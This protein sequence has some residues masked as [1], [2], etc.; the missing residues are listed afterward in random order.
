MAKK[1]DE[2][3]RDKDGKFTTSEAA[4]NEEVLNTTRSYI[5][6]SEDSRTA[7]DKLSRRNWA[8]YFS[9]Q[10]WT[11]KK[12]GQSKEFSPLTSMGV[13]SVAAFVKRTLTGFGNYF[14]MDIV[15]ES[16]MTSQQARDLLKFHLEDE[17]TD[18]VG[19]AVEPGIKI[20]LLSSVAIFKVRH[21]V[22]DDEFV[23][24]TDVEK[25]ER[26]FPDPTGRGLYEVHETVKDLHEIV[27]LAKQ[28]IYDKDEVAKV[29]TDFV[30]QDK[31]T[32][33]ERQKNHSQPVH[34][35]RKRITLHEVHGTIVNKEGEVIEEGIVATMANKKYLIRKPRKNPRFHKK[36]PFVMAPIIK[37][38]GSVWHKALYDDAVRINLYM[39]ELHNLILDGGLAAAH[40]VKMLRK[41]DLEDPDQASGGVPAGTTLIVKDDAPPNSKV[42]ETVK[43]GEVPADALNVLNLNQ[44]LFDMASMFNDIKAG[45]LPQK[46]V[47]ATEIVEKEQATSQQ[48]DGFA[49]TVE[50]AIDKV[51]RLAWAEIMQFRNNYFD[52]EHIIGGKA[53]L[54]L[55]MMSARERYDMFAKKTEFKVN[56]ISSLITRGKNFQK[57]MVAV[58]AMFKNPILAQA[59]SQRFSAKKIIDK[60]FEG[61]DLDASSIE[62]DK[63]EKGIPPEILQQLFGGQKTGANASAAGGRNPLPAETIPQPATKEGV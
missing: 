45:V 48:L 42:M 50:K 56:G 11:H 4:H 36:S 33:E 14:S 51:L 22:H 29:Q 8:A 47:K 27:K 59:F 2:K 1:K 39:N 44:R 34:N 16:I 15:N 41:G 38:P 19:T 30:E 6:E 28:G 18:F 61:L 54:A 43:T 25:P 60:I 32:E 40:D 23:L 52:V 37:V 63:G 49:R 62:L 10:D 46:Q 24:K 3:L 13:E 58:D 31:L 9:R 17:K 21:E 20:A 7:R 57:L 53:A 55:S 12:E 5:R 35:F 26:F